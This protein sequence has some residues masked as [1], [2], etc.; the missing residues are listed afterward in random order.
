MKSEKQIVY[1]LFC[2]PQEEV[3][4]EWKRTKKDKLREF[5]KRRKDVSFFFIVKYFFPL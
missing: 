4:A 3:E 2:R 1:H 5:K